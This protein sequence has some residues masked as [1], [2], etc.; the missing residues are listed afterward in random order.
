MIIGEMKSIKK[1]S[2]NE[3]DS[4]TGGVQITGDQAREFEYDWDEDD[5]LQSKKRAVK[6]KKTKAKVQS[7]VPIGAMQYADSQYNEGI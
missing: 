4:P 6:N 5:K 7:R 2:L 1:H 3:P